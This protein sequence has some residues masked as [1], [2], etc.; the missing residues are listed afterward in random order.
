MCS[1][2]LHTSEV[3]KFIKMFTNCK[4][5]SSNVSAGSPFDEFDFIP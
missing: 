5:Q 4:Y 3:G 2:D 1:D